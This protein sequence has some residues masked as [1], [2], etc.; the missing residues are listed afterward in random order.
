V[1]TRSCI[2]RQNGEGFT[3]VYHH[4]DGYPTG[5]GASLFHLYNGHFQK[6]IKV[7]LKTLIDDHPAGWSTIT[8]RDFSLEAGYIEL[9]KKNAENNWMSKGRPQC[10]CHGDRHEEAQVI[11]EKNA[12]DVGCEY[13]YVFDDNGRMRIMSSYNDDGSK[14]IGMFGSGNPDAG[15]RQIAIVELN[16][17]EPDWEEIGK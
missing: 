13:A 15:W 7:M 1:S 4:W 12:S 10:Y 3:G 17:K 16:G 8:D 9:D 14:M 11:T 6:D 2:A 5:L